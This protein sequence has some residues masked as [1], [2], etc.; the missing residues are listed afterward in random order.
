MRA[1][2]VVT[3]LAGAAHADNKL[4]FRFGFNRIPLEEERLGGFT[5][6]V[7]VEHEITR[8]LRAMA[9]Y[10]WM[11]LSVVPPDDA[12]VTEPA[13]SGMGHRGNLGVR[14][15]FEE[16]AFDEIRF[17]ADLETGGG[18]GMYEG[19][20]QTHVEPHGFVGIRGGY[21]IRTRRSRTTL[22]TELQ[23]RAVV[24]EQG[25]GFGGGLGFY[26]G[27]RATP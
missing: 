11:W 18:L 12:M 23:L 6:A 27:G 9:E 24:V 1:L 16:K 14:M 17:Y 20:M 26:W 13:V 25:I 22:E 19:G 21:T 7:G 5:L 15:N 4:G 8:K 3:A 10:E 2:L